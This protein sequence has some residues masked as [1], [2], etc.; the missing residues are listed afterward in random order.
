LKGRFF[1]FWVALS[2]LELMFSHSVNIQYSSAS[3]ALLDFADAA[4][5]Q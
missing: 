2:L 5:F 3:L 1:C 4:L